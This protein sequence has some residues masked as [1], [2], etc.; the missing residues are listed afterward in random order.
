MIESCLAGLQKI[1][2]APKDKEPP[3]CQLRLCKGGLRLCNP[4]LSTCN[5]P[6]V[7]MSAKTSCALSKTLWAR[8][9]DLTSVLSVLKRCVLK[10][11]AFAFGLRLRSKTRCFKTCVLGRSWRLPN[12]RP[13]ERLRFRDLRSKTLAFK[14]R[15]AIVFCV[16]KT[17]LGARACVQV[18][19]VQKTRRF[20]FAFLSPLSFCSSRP[21]LQGWNR[22]LSQIFQAFVFVLCSSLRRLGSNC[23]GEDFEIWGCKLVPLSVFLLSVPLVAGVNKLWGRF[24]ALRD[25]RTSFRPTTA[26]RILEFTV[27]TCLKSAEGSFRHVREVHHCGQMLQMDYLLPEDCWEI[28]DG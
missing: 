17:S 18:L 27:F 11:L 28:A 23:S 21:G 24:V 2:W 12:G 7:P 13:Q 9:A 22:Q 19:C 14:K 8:S 6:Y 1:F 3:K 26:L 15:I 4:M 5:K 16:L 10:T 20:A 25:T